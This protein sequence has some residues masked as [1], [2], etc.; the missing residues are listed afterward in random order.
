MEFH[1]RCPWSGWCFHPLLSHLPWTL[2]NWSSYSCPWKVS[3]CQIN[4]DELGKVMC[5]NIT[6]A[7]GW[8]L[9]SYVVCESPN[10]DNR[11]LMN[12]IFTLTFLLPFF[13]LCSFHSALLRHTSEHWLF[14]TCYRSEAKDCEGQTQAF[15]CTQIVH[16]SQAGCCTL[17][18]GTLEIEVFPIGRNNELKTAYVSNHSW[19]LSDDGHSRLQRR[20]SRNRKETH[21]EIGLYI[22]LGVHAGEVRE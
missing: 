4:C 11:F 9:N 12:R 3:G 8:F 13:F 18:I 2:L 17:E 15:I 22:F 21:K 1:L 20:H 19:Q 14:L 16:R 10:W 7:S 5:K 6:G